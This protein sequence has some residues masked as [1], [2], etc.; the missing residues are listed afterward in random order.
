[1]KLIILQLFSCFEHLIDYYKANVDAVDSYNRSALYYALML[2]NEETA[3]L[4][5]NKG[6]KMFGSLMPS[7]FDSA[8]LTFHFTEGSPFQIALSK[9]HFKIVKWIIDKESEYD[10]RSAII[11]AMSSTTPGTTALPSCLYA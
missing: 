2:P 8:S 11:L 9:G 10:M 3:L 6:A 7:L 1:M 5:I 4:L